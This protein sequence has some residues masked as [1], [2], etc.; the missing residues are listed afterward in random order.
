MFHYI[1]PPTHLDQLDRV[2]HLKACRETED[3]R[4]VTSER[5]LGTVQTRLDQLEREH[6]VSEGTRPLPSDRIY[7]FSVSYMPPSPPHRPIA[8][9][10]VALS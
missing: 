1:P 5:N 6:T 10:W 7:A 9:Q 3:G 2:E 8:S 4:L